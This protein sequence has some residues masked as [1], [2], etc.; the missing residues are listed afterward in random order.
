LAP[1]EYR[2]QGSV[3]INGSSPGRVIRND[4]ASTLRFEDGIVDIAG[5]SFANTV[6]GKAFKRELECLAG[7][8]HDNLVLGELG[9]GVNSAI[10]ILTGSP[11][12]DEKASGTLHIALGCNRPFD[13]VI[14]CDNHID[15][16]L[17]PQAVYA[18]KCEMPLN[19]GLAKQG[20][21]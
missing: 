11:I 2:A 6:S 17:I 12:H 1:V 7:Q 14:A 5:S 13:G 9:F 4:D 19:W 15:L 21:G 20:G 8:G 18:D 10:T 3:V 16:I